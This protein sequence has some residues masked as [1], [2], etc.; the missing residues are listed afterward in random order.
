[1]QFAHILFF[2]REAIAIPMAVKWM[3]LAPGRKERKISG[4]RREV[5]RK[6]GVIFKGGL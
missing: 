4:F 6:K 1:M 3:I 5:P 2:L